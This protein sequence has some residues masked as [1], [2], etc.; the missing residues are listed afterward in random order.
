M[1]YQAA[2]AARN[3]LRRKF[4]AFPACIS[5]HSTETGL[6]VRAV[7]HMRRCFLRVYPS[8]WRHIS[9]Q[10]LI[11]GAFTLSSKVPSLID[12]FACVVAPLHDA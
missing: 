4:G 1:P 3:E 10:Y 8:L 9:L 11:K 2:I 6:P 12:E 5:F 7:A